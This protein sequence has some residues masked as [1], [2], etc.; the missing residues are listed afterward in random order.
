MRNI[1]FFFTL[2]IL[3]S[4]C[5]STCDGSNECFD[6]R[7]AT[8]KNTMEVRSYQDVLGGTTVKDW[9]QGHGTQFEYLGKN[10]RAYLVYPGN[11]HVLPGHWAI[12][13]TGRDA[14]VCFRYPTN[15]YN[16]VTSESG[17][18]WK[19]RKALSF[20]KHL[21]EIRSGDLL[22]L[23]RT[24]KLPKILPKKI[25][26]SIKAAMKEVGYKAKLTRNKA[27]TW[28]RENCRP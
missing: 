10:G 7:I 5:Q 16:P 3:L 13:Q 26:I 28:N 27:C 18:R 11:T 21:E 17:G 25:N 12:V 9:S 2:L 6:K 19:C 8:S 22:R 20:V 24:S 4:G 1:L 15:S 23:K 14:E